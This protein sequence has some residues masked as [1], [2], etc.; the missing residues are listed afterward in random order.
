M[1]GWVRF[2][3]AADWLAAHRNQAVSANPD[4]TL[5]QSSPEL[6]VAFEKFMQKY[7]ASSGRNTLS[8]KEREVLFANFMKFLAESKAEQAAAR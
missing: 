3:P 1:P 6:R 8:T 7:A 4:S 2:K 5:S